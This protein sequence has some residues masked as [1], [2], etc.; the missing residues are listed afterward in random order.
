VDAVE[1][2]EATFIARMT[3]STTHELRNVL[4]VVKES[5]GLVEDLMLASQQQKSVNPEKLLHAARRIDAQV[6]RGAALL[7]S[8][9]RLAHGLD[10]AEEALDLAQQIEQVAFLCQRF[11]RQRRQRIEVE[12]K[13]DARSVR[14]NTLRLQMAL[15]SAIDCCLEQLPEDAV[16]TLRVAGGADRPAIVVT[17]AAGAHGLPAPAGAASWPR[18]VDLVRRLEAS[19]E[20]AD[21]PFGFRIVFS[22]ETHGR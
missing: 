2:P 19:I 20:A 4:A 3:A 15:V 14:G 5:A 7:T 11:A 10:H 21:E 17:G 13:G 12:A 18:L 22:G 8:L 1:N 6:G 16:V 9:N